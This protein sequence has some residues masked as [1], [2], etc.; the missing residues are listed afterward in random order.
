MALSLAACGG[1]T[2]PVAVVDTTPVVDPAVTAAE[3]AQAAAEA[4]QATAEA[5]QAAAEAELAAALN[6]PAVTSAL[7]TTQDIVVTT[8]SSDTITGTSS[9]YTGNDV[10]S[11]ASTSDSDTLT[12]AATDD[13]TATPTVVNIENI[14]F[15]LDTIVTTGGVDTAFDVDLAGVT[16]GTVTLD[17]VKAT[18]VVTTANVTNI[19][20]GVTVQTDLNGT[21]AAAADSTVTLDLTKATSQTVT[22]VT[23]TLDNLTINADA[24]TLL[25]ITDSNAENATVITN[26]G[27]VTITDLTPATA[28]ATATSLDVTAGGVIT[29]TAMNQVG[30]MG[31]STTSGNVVIG[32]GAGDV[33][34]TSV[35]A[36]TDAGNIT[37]TNV[38]DATSVTLSATGDGDANAAAA[39]GDVTVTDA[40]AATS[41]TIT[42]SG[43]I[44]IASSDVVRDMSL[45]AGQ[46]STLA[47]VNNVMS[48]T[49]AS[50]GATATTFTAATG[51]DEL[52]NID[53]ITFAGAGDS[54]LIVDAT[55]IAAAAASTFRSTTAAKVAASDTGTGVSTIR[56]MENQAANALDLSGL[57]VDAIEFGT[58]STMTAAA[59]VA[60][61]ANIAIGADQAA[62]IL[63]AAA[64]AGNTVTITIDDDAAAVDTNSYDITTLTT[65]NIGTVNIAANDTEEAH[66]LTTV[67]VGAANDVVVTGAGAVTVGTSVTAKTYDASASTGAQTIQLIANATVFKTG[68]GADTFTASAAAAHTIDA[69]AG[70][71]TLSVDD[72][73]D[74]SAVALSL[75]GIDKLDVDGNG[76]AAYNGTF[77]SADFSG[78]SILII[79]DSAAN[80][81]VT[82]TAQSGLGE[83][84]DLSGID[85]RLAAVTV[86]GTAGADVITGSASG[87]MTINGAAGAD[88]ITGGSAADILN[89]DG[90]ADTINGGG[91]ADAITGGA[92]VDTLTGG[93]GNDDFTQTFTDVD[94]TA[95][96]VTDIITDFATG[97]DTISVGTAGGAAT[98]S[99]ATATVDNL[100]DLLVAAGTALDGTVKI[101]VGQVTGG[102]AYA[103][104]DD[105]GTGYSSVIELQSVALDTI[106]ATD[107]VV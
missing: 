67:N 94:T 74:F 89:G 70:V 99:E 8:T 6:P 65:T 76:V 104:L 38:A 57:A 34:A 42:A 45:T 9:T 12:I 27:A 51:S 26:A 91:G 87:I 43:G 53:T 22:N 75:T 16:N 92:G 56:I 102:N 36:S 98:Y 69:G 88:T 100:T 86:N 77:D 84:T 48:L 83:T 32:V 72:N 63:T 107:F 17:V 106:A 61:G 31:L 81:V 5:A 24:A 46:A 7:A 62:V 97:K 15:N 40:S 3:A 55:D 47:N 11:D 64:T 33:D 95:G 85:V 25:T 4:A 39:D 50:T 1:S 73:L 54:T 68:S 41:M 60:S 29:V 59:T 21:Y 96:A 101:Y 20:S 28:T 44:S 79:G 35:T 30:S 71:D 23:G 13:I 49:L 52:N 10:I 66:A 58:N 37:A 14:A 90:G 103:V 80:D 93:A 105:D 78:Q 18:S 19:K 2:T 82:L